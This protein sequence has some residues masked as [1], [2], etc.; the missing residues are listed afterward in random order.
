MNC[1][2]GFG[3][4]LAGQPSLSDF[5]RCTLLA[6]GAAVGKVVRDATCNEYCAAGWICT[7]LSLVKAVFAAFFASQRRRRPCHR[8]E[9]LLLELVELPFAHLILGVAARII[10][11][12]PGHLI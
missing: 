5:F 8:I 12:Y 4:F 1:T 9:T 11:F 2:R 10:A 6:F 3:L 7:F